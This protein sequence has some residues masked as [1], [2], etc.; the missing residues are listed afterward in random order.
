[1]RETASNLGDSSLAP[2]FA[3]YR[4]AAAG[5]IMLEFLTWPEIDGLISRGFRRIIVPMGS[6]EQHGPRLP[7]NNDSLIATALSSSAAERLGSTLVAPVIQPGFSPHH[8][9]FPGTISVEKRLLVGYVRAYLQCLAAAG[10]DELYLLSGHGG[11]FGPVLEA[12]DR[13][14]PS[15]PSGVRIGHSLNLD[16]Y[17]NEMLR[18]LREIGMPTPTLNH[19]D[20]SELSLT[21]FL[22]P[23]LVRDGQDVPGLMGEIHL[24]DLIRKGIRGV[25]PSGILGDP[26]GS[27]ARLG[28]KVFASL[29]EYVVMSF[30]A[31]LR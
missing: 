14:R 21:M 5:P 24:S 23:D 3:G 2:P 4:G 25:S 9:G 29:V 31:S 22:A 27:N 20:A 13:L 6:I 11:N 8:R 30:K 17:I 18:P 26:R 15:L 19:A 1:M 28:G 16:G 10:F 12:I 7:L